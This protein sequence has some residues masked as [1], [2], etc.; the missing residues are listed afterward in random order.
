MLHEEERIKEYLNNL[1]FYSVL[2]IQN[3]H[4]IVHPELKT[5]KEHINK[6]YEEFPGGKPYLEKLLS[7]VYEGAPLGLEPLKLVTATFNTVLQPI[8]NKLDELG[9]AQG[10]Q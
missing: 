10:Q 6:F 5:S 9:K 4:R 7:H 1:A 8:L 2:S 3:Y